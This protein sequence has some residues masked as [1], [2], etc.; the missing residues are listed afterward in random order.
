MNLILLIHLTNFFFNIQVLGQSVEG[1]EPALI[2][3]KA[4][5]TEFDE[6]A[7]KYDETAAKFVPPDAD[8]AAK[9][10][11]EQKTVTRIV[12]YEVKELFR[13]KFYI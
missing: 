9:K 6:N 7:K 12:T 4:L 11:V 13:H 5:A 8:I 10:T 3:L 1:Q 2:K